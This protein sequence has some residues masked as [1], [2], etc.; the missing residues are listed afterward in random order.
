MKWST[1]DFANTIGGRT[2][3]TLAPGPAALIRT[4][5]RRKPLTSF[6]VVPA[7][8]VFL[9]GSLTISIPTNRPAPPDVA[10][11]FMALRQPLELGFQIGAYLPRIR[12]Q[13]V[14]L[15]H[16]E[17]GL[18]RGARHGVSSESVE[19]ARLAA[20]LFDN[21]GPH[22]DAGDRLAVAHRFEDVTPGQA[23]EVDRLY[24]HLLASSEQV[25]N[26]H[27]YV[28]RKLKLGRSGDEV[29]PGWQVT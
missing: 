29:R 24:D 18:R 13:L 14:P 16:I 10:D 1:F 22:R 28:Y 6:V 5:L 15:D 19:V 12:D 23:R 20:K 27:P 7:S 3:S 25:R 2:F 8:G 9:A 4:R 11:R 26:R 21:L 17:N